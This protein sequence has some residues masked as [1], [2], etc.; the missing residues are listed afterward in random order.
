VDFALGAW[1]LRWEQ[2]IN[3]TLITT[4]YQS[5]HFVEFLRDAMLRADTI[6]RQ[7]SYHLEWMD[8]R[9][10]IDELRAR[11]NLPPLPD[12]KGNVSYVP[13]NMIPIES[14]G[15]AQNEA[16]RSL[17]VPD[18]MAALASIQAA[19]GQAVPPEVQP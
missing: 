13:L 3:A 5:T 9:A 12:G 18:A 1:L 16:A 10:T 11:E 8:G 15:L 14:A 2:A 19:S 6:T 4:P 17:P 7:Q